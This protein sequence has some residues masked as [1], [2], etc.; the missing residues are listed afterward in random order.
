LSSVAVQFV[1]FALM[2]RFSTVQT[3]TFVGFTIAVVLDDFSGGPAAS[4][5]AALALKARSGLVPIIEERIGREQAERI[6]TAV[7]TAADFARHEAGEGVSALVFILS[8]ERGAARKAEIAD[9]QIRA[10]QGLKI[11]V[12]ERSASAG[13]GGASAS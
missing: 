13:G 10:G 11:I 8:G 2:W 9:Q 1:A 6:G 12:Q 5:A 4:A 7:R 3:V